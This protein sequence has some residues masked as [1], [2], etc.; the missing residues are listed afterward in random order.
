MSS[1][2]NSDDNAPKKLDWLVAAG[3][4][5]FMIA[6]IGA[7]FGQN[8]RWLGAAFMIMPVVIGFGLANNIKNMQPDWGKQGEDVEIY[9]PD[10]PESLTSASGSASNK[11]KSKREYWTSIALFALGGLFFFGLGL[12]ITF[13]EFVVENF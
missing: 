8:I 1:K 2:F 7:V 9:V 3:F 11:P 5:I 4:V 12:F 6:M 13:S 10:A